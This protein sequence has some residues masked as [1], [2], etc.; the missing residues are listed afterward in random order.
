MK[1][2]CR[3]VKNAHFLHSVNYLLRCPA[4][5]CDKRNS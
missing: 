1:Q 2:A 4:W 3:Y 5:R